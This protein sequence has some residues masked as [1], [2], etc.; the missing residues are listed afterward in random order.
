VDRDKV[1]EKEGWVEEEGNKNFMRWKRGAGR[2][3]GWI[4]K[5]WMDEKGGKRWRERE[6]GKKEEAWIKNEGSNKRHGWRMRAERRA[7]KENE[8]SKR[9][10]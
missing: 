9:L 1:K 4:E 8:G 7:W 6:R 10:E 5:E 2:G 3:G